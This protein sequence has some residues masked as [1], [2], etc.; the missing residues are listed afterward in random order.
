MPRQKKTLVPSSVV[1]A[2]VPTFLTTQRTLLIPQGRKKKKKNT[3]SPNTPNARDVLRDVD[4]ECV[5]VVTPRCDAA[6]CVRVSVCAV[7]TV[8]A[9]DKL[10]M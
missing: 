10:M 6:V 2:T 3:H 4:A 5:S 1:L 9:V 7:C 8:L